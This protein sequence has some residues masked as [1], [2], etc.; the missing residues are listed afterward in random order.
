MPSTDATER[1][2]PSTE[3]RTSGYSSPRHSKRTEPK[4]VR[5]PISPVTRITGATRSHRSAA[6][7][8][9]SGDA[10]LSR[11]L[12][13]EATWLMYGR[14]RGPRARIAVEKPSSTPSA[15]RCSR[16]VALEVAAAPC[17]WNA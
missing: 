3:P 12:T 17:E 6:C 7:M 8:R 15:S 16:R 13:L 9:A 14:A 11:C 2:A 1:S 4:W 5:R 10:M